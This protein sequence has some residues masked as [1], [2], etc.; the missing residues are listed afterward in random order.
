MNAVLTAGAAP[1]WMCVRVA[2]VEFALP[3]ELV[4]EVLPTPALSQVPMVPAW[5]AGMVSV[6]N[7]VIPVVDAGVRLLGTPAQRAGRLVLSAPDETGERVGILVDD[8]TG[9]IDR[10]SATLGAPKGETTL[11]ARFVSAVVS[12]AGAPPVEVL[13][14]DVLLDPTV[15]R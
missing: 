6:R 3:I 14:L 5:V 15:E 13:N 10:G 1:G 11:P 4:G 12:A 8:V 9:L 2:G 7:E